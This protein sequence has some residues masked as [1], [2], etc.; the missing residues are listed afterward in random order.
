MS[1]QRRAAAIRLYDRY[2]HE[3]M[4]RRAFMAELTRIAGSAAAA[5][6]LL[7]GIAADPAAAALV[8]PDDRRVAG[9]RMRWPIGGGRT[10]LGYQGEPRDA[11]RPLG[12]VLVVHENRGLNA[13]IE[14]VA[15]RLAV[16][17]YRAVAPDFLSEAGGTPA[18][19]DAA[20][21]AIGKLDLG[22]AAADAVATLQLLA[23]L[24]NA[25]GKLGAVGFCWGGGMVNRM[26]VE[27]GPALDAGVPFYGPAPD[28][29][30]AARVEAAMLLHYAGED[31]RVNKT[32]LPWAEAL[33]AAGKKVESFVYRG[34]QHAF[35]NDT[36]AERYDAAAAKLAW[37]R[38]LDFF[39][40]ELA[41]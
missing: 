13:H 21:E 22:R 36:S 14:D 3:G 27:S 40:R 19:Q 38:T 37:Q 10:M 23:N 2:T 11:S 41:A 7:A 6:A 29:A 8:A 32:G 5:S 31:E 39:A 33:R 17:G 30:L 18:D 20:R 9:R 15:R 1:R 4:D 12:S 24:P 34:V 28:P 16:A 25:N 35:H 26:A